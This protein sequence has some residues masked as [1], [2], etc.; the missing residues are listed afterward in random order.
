MGSSRRKPHI[1]DEGAGLLDPGPVSQSEVDEFDFVIFSEKNVLG[2]EI[3]VDDIV[4]LVN[5][6]GGFDDLAGIVL[7]D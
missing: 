1:A 4:I 2:L 7:V 3:A 6:V 5:S